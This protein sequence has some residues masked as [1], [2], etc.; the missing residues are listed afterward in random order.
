MLKLLLV[1]L[2]GERHKTLQTALDEIFRTGPRNNQLDFR[3]DNGSL[4]GSRI[5]FAGFFIYYKRG[6]CDDFKVPLDG[7]VCDKM[8]KIT[9]TE[10]DEDTDS[11]AF[12]ILVTIPT[13]LLV[14]TD[15]GQN[16]HNIRQ[17]V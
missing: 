17:T 11:P 6:S 1:C 10:N 7:A 8:T 13:A 3:N 9:L 4:I 12:F 16:T 15:Y 14:Y 5:C 2:I